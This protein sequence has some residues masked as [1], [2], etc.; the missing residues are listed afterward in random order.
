MPD[1]Q[2]APKLSVIVA[3]HNVQDYALNTLRSLV[4]NAG[5]ATEFLLVDDH[6]TDATAEL[7]GR[8]LPG[9]P[10]GRLLA[11][12]TN[13]GIS[14]A[15]NTGIEAARGEY[16]TFLD[17]DDWYAPGYLD[18]LVAAIDRLGVDFVRTD[19]VQAT[20]RN[21]EVV[22]APA[23]RREAVLDPREGILP[24]NAKTMVD[25]PFVWAGIY[26]RRV[27]DEGLRFDERLR[28][29]E[30]RVFGWQLHLRA[31]SFAAV[32]LF[33]VFYRRGVGTSLTQ[34]TDARQ[35]DF[36]PAHEQIMAEVRA[37]RDAERLLPKIVRT[38]CA[39]IAF[40]VGNASRYEAQ[41]A[42]RLRQ[43]AAAALRR[44][45]AGLLDQTLTA[46]GDRGRV[47]RRLVGR[48]TR[49]AAA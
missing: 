42:R 2:N 7:I 10:G 48:T 37:D 15:R 31:R 16:L 23:R 32:G 9:L 30:D 13:R 36:L 49:K 24:A 12:E 8:A 4:R 18:R 22:R 47:L 14:A 3:C 11:H 5:P 27:F 35:L 43:E 20:G 28:T 1:K 34:I 25:Y 21:R 33:G 44:M 39:M 38:Y 26:H 29:A 17:G 46:M 19:H 6:S 45:P 40:H 41:A